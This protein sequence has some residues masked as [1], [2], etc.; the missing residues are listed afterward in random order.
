MDATLAIARRPRSLTATE[1]VKRQMYI[2]VYIRNCY[3]RY[4]RV[5]IVK[6]K[7]H[8]DLNSSCKYLYIIHFDVGGENGVV[9]KGAVYGDMMMKRRH[10]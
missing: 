4:Y 6:L 10:K 8:M 9:E 5:C 7:L 1:E 3:V 2:G